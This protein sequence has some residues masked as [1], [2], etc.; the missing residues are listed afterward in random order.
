MT[1]VHPQFMVGRLHCRAD[2][3]LRTL[4]R[5]RTLGA[6]LVAVLA[7]V[8]GV[9]AQRPATVSVTGIVVDATGAVLPRA[10]VDLAP[11]NG[12][13]ASTTTDAGGAFRFERVPPGRY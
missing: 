3:R 6:V 8:R 1:R 7:A 5:H 13:P 12:A 4:A 2:V 11:S 9:N 10:A